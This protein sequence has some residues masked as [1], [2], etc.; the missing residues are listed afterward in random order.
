[1]DGEVLDRL[2][3]DRALGGL[4]PDVEVL[5]AAYLEQTPTAAA[6]AGDY[7]AAADAARRVLRGDGPAT[8]P[9][10]PA[11]RLHRVAEARRRLRL[12]RHVAGLAAALVLGV[13]LGAGLFRAQAPRGG[14]VTPV[15][16]DRPFAAADERPA[17][18]DFWSAARLYERARHMRQTRSARWIWDSAVSRP[19]VGGES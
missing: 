13:G 2:L 6:R 19:R 3:M 15:G 1:M 9:P 14:T 18:G 5:L 4:S 10:F 11:V 16:G 8:L 7:N 17:T 12:V